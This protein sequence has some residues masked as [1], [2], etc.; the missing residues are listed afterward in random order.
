LPTLYR[1]PSGD[2]HDITSGNNG[3]YTAGPGYDLVTGR[4]TPIA[5]LIVAGLVGS[6]SSQPPPTNPPPW[7]VVPAS[8]A[9]T[10]VTGTT[11]SLH[12]MGNDA[13]GASSLTYT[14]SV[15]SAPAGATRPTLSINGNN[16]AQN[17]TVTFFQAGTYVFQ[18]AITDPAGQTVTSNVMVLVGQ[19][20][21]S[22]VLA[23]GN[24]RLS[25]GGTQQFTALAKDQFGNAMSI[26]SGWTWTVQGGGT[27]DG[28]GLYHA[29]LGGTGI[30][31]VQVSADGLS[32]TIA[33]SFAPASNPLVPIGFNPADPWTT[34]QSILDAFM[35][36]LNL[37]ESL[38][39]SL[40]ASWH[41]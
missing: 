31:I 8:A 6:T 33:V 9:T 21:T 40:L 2:F 22:V 41:G 36:E 39:Q 5:N 37:F 11:T 28:N 34:W 4:G 20:L 26:P 30:A 17:T 13:S 35:A 7:L 14:W 25:N 19:T 24:A 16:A 32:S 10:Q 12:V 1:L 38:W 18:A 15:L 3:G 29:P 23:P 27:I